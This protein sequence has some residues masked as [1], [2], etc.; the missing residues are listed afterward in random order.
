MP[1]RMALGKAAITDIDVA[2]NQDLKALFPKRPLDTRYL[3]HFLLWRGAYL[4]AQ[5]SGATV[6]GITLDTLGSLSVPL[7]GDT[8]EQCRI[9]TILDKADSIRARRRATLTL[10]GDF[11]RAAFI[12]LFGDPVIN[13]KAWPVD[14]L[15][16]VADIRS[17]IT[18]GRKLNGAAT[19]P[20]AYMRVANVQDSY[21][22]L[23]EIKTIEA[24]EAEIERYALKSG[25]VLLTEG[26]D[27]DKLGRGAVWSA[28]IDE[29]IHQNHIFA[30][31]LHKGSALSPGYL[32]EL[33]GSEY[34]KRYFLRAAKQTTGIA[35]INSTQLKAFPVLIPDSDCVE[36]W[37]MIQAMAANQKQR[38]NR[39][40]V[41]ADALYAALADRAFNG[42]L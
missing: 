38:A 18:V 29:C 28:P 21:I 6:K 19:R 4:E 14:R 33:I 32:S 22:S 41:E 34:G 9:A 8:N 12:D 23:A 39:A 31:R 7:P 1:T 37:S 15:D 36:R 42:E 24:T 35:S 17:G 20:V 3:L 40:V 16:S 25:D 5:G 10:I 30:V 11:L 13:S 26:G 2:I 27:P